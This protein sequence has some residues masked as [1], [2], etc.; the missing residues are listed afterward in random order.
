MGQYY[1]GK[2]PSNEPMPDDPGVRWCAWLRCEHCREV[3]LHAV[4]ADNLNHRWGSA[5]CDR[6]RSNRLRDRSRRR[7]QRRLA[8]FAAEGIAVIEKL[9]SEEMQV[10]S[11]T[12]EVVEYDD[13]RGMEIRISAAATPEQVLHGIEVAEDVIDE[14]DRLGAWMRTDRGRW[15]GLALRA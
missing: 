10:D 9:S 4:L 12:L 2:N 3:T 13:P 8:G 11:A 1:R 14:P 15:R 5:G 7:I 6:E